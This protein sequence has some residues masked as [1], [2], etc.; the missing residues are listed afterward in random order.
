VVGLTVG[1]FRDKPLDSTLFLMS[2][3]FGNVVGLTVFICS[4]ALYPVLRNLAPA[5][6]W[7][8]LGIG[9]LGI[10]RGTRSCSGASCTSLCRTHGKPLRCSR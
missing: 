5:V 4:V 9:L 1:L 6:R 8:L 10:G 3:L 2:L 7:A